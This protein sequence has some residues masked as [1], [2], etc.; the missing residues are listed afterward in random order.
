MS[1]DGKSELRDASGGGVA[2][3]HPSPDPFHFLVGPATAGEFNTARLRLLPIACLRVDDVR[4]KFDSS[5]IVFDPEDDPADQSDP[6]DLRT[7]MRHLA[8]LVKANPGS[9]L[10]IFGHADPVGNDDYNKV[11]SGRRAMAIYGMLI[12]ETGLW[13]TLF[14]GPKAIA[15]DNWGNDALEVMA[16]AT[17]LSS[18]TPRAS[19]FKAYMDTLCPDGFRLQKSDFLAQGADSGGGKGDFQGCGEFNPLLVFSQEKQ[20]KFDKA[21]RDNGKEDQLVLTDRNKQNAPNRRVM[22]FLFKKGSKID[23]AKW[24]CP[25]ATEGVATCKKRFFSDGDTRRS[26]HLRGKDRRF[27]DTQDT[28]ACRF[29]QRLAD[30]SP[31]EQLLLG[32]ATF[33]IIRAA[34]GTPVKNTLFEV[35]FPNGNP[36]KIRSNA[37]GFIRLVGAEGQIFTLVQ[38]ADPNVPGDL[39]DASNLG[40]S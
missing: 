1:P 22:V 5:F 40:G 23:I 36:R 38:I 21:A 31:C 37:D 28:F 25:R 32:I 33:R 15:G 26:T 17:G 6:E 7:E 35:R 12:R 14:S 34:D 39:S 8:R 19:L 4:F 30:T 29:Y 10:S 16:A 9:P 13:E 24:P 18:N 3:D 2:A 20:E 11:L 27:K